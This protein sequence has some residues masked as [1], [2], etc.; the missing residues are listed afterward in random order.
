MLLFQC[1]SCGKNEKVENMAAYVKYIDGRDLIHIGQSLDSTSKYHFCKKCC[2]RLPLN[3]LYGLAAGTVADGTRAAIN[4]LTEREREIITHVASGWSLKQAAAKMEITIDTANKHIAGVKNKLFANN[5]A[6]AVAK[7]IY[8]NIINIGQLKFKD[9]IM[10]YR[11]NNFADYNKQLQEDAQ[12]IEYIKTEDGFDSIGVPMVEALED[13][14]IEDYASE[15][16]FDE[17]DEGESKK[18][19]PQK[20]NYE[21]RVEIDRT[22]ESIENNIENYE[23]IYAKDVVK[24]T[25]IPESFKRMGIDL[26][27]GMRARVVSRSTHDNKSYKIKLMDT[28]QLIDV[29]RCCVAKIK[30]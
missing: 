15:A 10:Q 21:K 8:L 24:L 11:P 6:S 14:D 2:D 18:Q 23:A 25:E 29:D 5:Q 17:E 12:K 9:R 28:G 3:L 4:L 22:N 27:V 7:A 20:P 13:D 19:D 16:D 1:N 26:W 30:E